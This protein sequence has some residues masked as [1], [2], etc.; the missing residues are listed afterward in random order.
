M[1]YMRFFAL[2]LSLCLLAGCSI[3]PFQTPEEQRAAQ[4]A[5]EALKRE[6]QTQ[7]DPFAALDS[8]FTLKRTLTNSAGATLATY[9]V[10]F[11][12]FSEN[13]EKAQSFA[14][15]NNYYENE[16]T[17]LI[18]DAYSFFGE[19]KKVYGEGWDTVTAA[20]KAFNIRIDYQLLEAPE[21]YLCVRCDFHVEENGQ[22]EEYTQAQVFLLDNGWQLTLEALFGT[23]YESAAPKLMASI[24]AWC[25]NNGISVTGAENRTIE[26]FSGNYALTTE[27]FLF[28]TE[29]FQL[30][31]KNPNRYSIPVTLSGYR[32][33]LED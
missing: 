13:G 30:N 3:V 5:A 24:L 19:V 7:A 11:P 21:G 10:A 31:N 6:A 33:V 4:E 17:G 14:R 8:A 27:G 2:L 18:Q 20:D 32:S 29:P 12:K 15:I 9:E 25:N 22:V 26:E 23:Q 1:K 28:Y 16:I